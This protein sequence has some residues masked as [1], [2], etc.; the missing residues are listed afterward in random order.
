MEKFKLLRWSTK[1]FLGSQNIPIVS[2]PTA[3]IAFKGP[4]VVLVSEMPS[5]S[6]D[7]LV[8]FRGFQP[9]SR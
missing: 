1:S 8:K 5:I 2:E 9:S 3:G 7:D 6:K 4:G